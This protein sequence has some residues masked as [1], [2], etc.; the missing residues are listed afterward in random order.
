MLQSMP[1]VI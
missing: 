1:Q